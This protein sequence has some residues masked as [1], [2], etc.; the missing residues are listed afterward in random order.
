MT[1]QEPKRKKRGRVA[2][3]GA[4]ANRAIPFKGRLYEPLR[5]AMP[6]R[7]K[8]RL[9]PMRVTGIITV[10]VDNSHSFVL[11]SRGSRIENDLYWRGYGQGWEAMSLRLWR[12]FVPLAKTIVDVGAQEGIYSLAAKCLNPAAAVYAFEPLPN[13]FDWLKASID[14]NKLE[15]VAVS[16]AVSDV[17]GTATLYDPDKQ[18]GM[19]T[20][21]TRPSEP[22][23]E[24]ST[25]TVRLDDFARQQGL[26]SIDLLKIDIEGHEPAAIRGLGEL[27]STSA[28]PMLIEILSDQAGAAIWE[29]VGPAG[30]QA[31][32]LDD[33]K[34]IFRESELKWVSNKKRNY[35]LSNDAALGA[36]GLSK[37]P[38]GS[39]ALPAIVSQHA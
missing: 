36:S 2:A 19:A 18:H 32:L 16:A 12:H 6:R 29:I 8:R 17:T 5:R 23:A 24:I 38:D 1:D 7:I 27:L 14:L 34:G 10:A 11:A 13:S 30:Y 39:Y 28:P 33:V 25:K 15:V 4:A 37:L 22:H 31:Y 35:L 20:L 3:L 21:E 9:K 26:A